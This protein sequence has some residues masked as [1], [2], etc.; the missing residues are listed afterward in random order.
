[1]E[2][3][4]SLITCLERLKTLSMEEVWRTLRS[5]GYENSLK[6]LRAFTKMDG[7]YSILKK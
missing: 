7:K 4:K 3:L 5:K 1:M 6:T 2:D